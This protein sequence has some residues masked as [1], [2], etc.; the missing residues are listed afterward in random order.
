MAPPPNRR[1]M[2]AKKSHF[3]NFL[4]LDTTHRFTHFPA[5]DFPEI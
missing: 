3:P 1:K 4:T 5:A 2:A